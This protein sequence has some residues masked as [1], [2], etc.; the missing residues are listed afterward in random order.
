M[1]ILTVWAIWSTQSIR[2]IWNGYSERPNN[3]EWV[4]PRLI[5]NYVILGYTQE[6]YLM[7]PY[8]GTRKNNALLHHS[9]V[10]PRM[11]PNDIL[12]G[13][14][15]KWYVTI[16]SW[17]H[18]RMIPNDAIIEYLQGWYLILSFLGTHKNDTYVYH[19]GYTQEWCLK[20]SFL[21]TPMNDTQLYNSC[22]HIRMIP[23]Y[24]ILRCT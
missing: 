14:P 18:A 20:M 9:W 7:A 23:N 8:M 17:V 6:W 13:K 3:L 24:I 10:R 2:V 12:L 19:F 15:E 21:G 1:G 22:V 11:I 5:P 4:H 16:S